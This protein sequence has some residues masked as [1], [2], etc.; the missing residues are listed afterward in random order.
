MHAS[1]LQ[2]ASLDNP[3]YYLQ[4]ARALI[5]WVLSH[6]AEL[7]LPE[8]RQQLEQL[9]KLPDQ[10]QAL[11]VRMLMR[12][13]ERFRLSALSYQEIGDVAPWLR[14]LEALGLVQTHSQ[15]SAEDL[16]ALLTKPELLTLLRSLGLKA[17]ASS[18]KPLLIE[19][20]SQHQPQ[21]LTWSNWWLQ[22]ENAPPTLREDEVI[23]LCVSALFERVQL[24]FFGNLRQNLSEFVLTELGH[25]RYE[26]V[27]FTPASRA[28]ATRDEV[29]FYLQL[30]RLRERLEEG[31]T[32][33]AELLN[34]IPQ[35]LAENLWLA[36][37]QSR[38]FYSLGYQAERSGQ[39]DLALAAYD[40]AQHREGQVRRVRILEKQNKMDDAYEAAMTAYETVTTPVERENLQRLLKRLARKTGAAF[41]VFHRPMLKEETLTL[42]YFAGRVEQAAAT[43]YSAQGGH[44]DYAENALF[45]GLFALLC[46]PVLYTPLP[47][48]FFNPF[49]SGPQDLHRDD[50]FTRR[51]ALLD[52]ALATLDTGTYASL[53]LQRFDEH[54]GKS[55]PLMIWP[56][57]NKAL[58]E[59]ALERIPAA[60]LRLIFERLI[61]DIRHH[62]SG[63]PDL[64]YWPD[65][66]G[67]ELIE[68]K[69]PGDRL[70]DNQK[71][72]ADFLLT[73]GINMRV[74]HVRWLDVE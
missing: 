19:Q 10:A 60:D 38:L 23:E 7:L 3:F 37:R 27:D 61:V 2:A 42:P 40:L 30:Q 11:L 1:E 34:E 63:L 13:G 57:L 9:L 53:I 70:Q 45:T 58:L 25:Q 54:Y 5:R 71:Q 69:G 33:L 20:L 55:C 46:W 67:Y 74:C 24:M 64:I 26:V 62:R 48:A 51:Q 14:Q 22:A 32:D 17:L 59:R 4:N 66:G 43:Y 35:P 16:S 28:F 15:F 39:W 68:V 41:P 12:K 31:S 18:K 6:Y 73:Q 29:D 8:E 50:F 49:Q 65:S 52:E 47:G 72:W 56:L 21:S 44:C 36:S